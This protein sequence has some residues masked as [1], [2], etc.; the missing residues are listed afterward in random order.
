MTVTRKEW[1][2]HTMYQRINT[3]LVELY[4]LQSDVGSVHAEDKVRFDLESCGDALTVPKE[5]VAER[6]K[7]T[8]QIQKRLA[9]HPARVRNDVLG[10]RD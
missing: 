3:R 1:D 9:S 6:S 8:R 4:F 10:R 7:G 5:R 2:G